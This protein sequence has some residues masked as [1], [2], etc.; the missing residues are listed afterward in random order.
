[1]RS[2]ARCLPSLRLRAAKALYMATMTDTPYLDCINAPLVYFSP[3]IALLVAVAVAT[4]HHNSDVPFSHPAFFLNCLPPP[5]C[6][7]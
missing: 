6:P 7:R 3:C 2:A 1:M 5:F 4:A